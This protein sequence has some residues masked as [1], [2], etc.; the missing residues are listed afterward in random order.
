MSGTH[1]LHGIKKSVAKYTKF[2]F[3]FFKAKNKRINSGLV[4][5]DSQEKF[6]CDW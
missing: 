5:Y 4:E 3:D 2:L 6:D 1:R